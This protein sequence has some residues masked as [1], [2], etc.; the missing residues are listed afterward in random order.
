MLK[1]AAKCSATA[2]L[3]AI[4]KTAAFSG[5]K[6]RPLNAKKTAAKCHFFYSEYISPAIAVDNPAT[7]V[8]VDVLPLSISVDRHHY[9]I[10][11][12][13]LGTFAIVGCLKHT[14]ILP[15]FV[16]DPTYQEI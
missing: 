14:H 5:D 1:T 2:D 11:T 4:L 12:A 9:Q 7:F 16:P 6:K 10:V 13:Q 15:R 3:A 8:I